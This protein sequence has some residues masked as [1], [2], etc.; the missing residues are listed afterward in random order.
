ML[1]HRSSAIRLSLRMH[2][3]CKRERD[4]SSTRQR[5]VL[6][7]LCLL[8]LLTSLITHLAT[9]H[10]PLAGASSLYLDGCARP[11]ATTDQSTRVYFLPS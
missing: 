6:R 8:D 11:A 1:L 5:V 2:R 9:R 3:T 10:E 4:M 7:P